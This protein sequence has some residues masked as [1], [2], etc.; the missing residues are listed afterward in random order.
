MPHFAATKYM[1]RAA[2]CSQGTYCHRRGE[3]QAGVEFT[4]I[5]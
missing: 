4:K 1:G 5:P 2:Q 3:W